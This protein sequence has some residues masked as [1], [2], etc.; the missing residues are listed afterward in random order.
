MDIIKFLI[1]DALED[2]EENKDD[3]TEEMIS[4]LLDMVIDKMK[5]PKIERIISNNPLTIILWEDKTKTIVKCMEEE[6][7]D[8]EKGVMTALL[9][10]IYGKK[11]LK[12]ILHSVFYQKET[13]DKHGKN[14]FIRVN[15]KGDTK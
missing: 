7:F 10:K 6:S 9:T 3:L 11:E 5:L 1:D 13:V 12:E 4:D 15:E 14:V 8:T 2:T